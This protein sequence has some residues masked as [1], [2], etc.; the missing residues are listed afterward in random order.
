MGNKL[1]YGNLPRLLLAWV[2]TEA[3]RTQRREL[4]LGRSL[5]EFMRR[6]GIYSTSGGTWGIRTRLRNQMD[7]LFNAHVQLIHEDE[8]GKQFIS[9]TIADQGE[10][11][12]DPK[13][14]NEPVLW[15]SKIELGE[16]P[17]PGD[18]PAPRPAGHEHPESNQA[19]LAGTGPLHMAHLPDL[20]LEEAGEAALAGSLPPV[21]GEPGAGGKQ[22]APWMPSG[23][24]ASG[25]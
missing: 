24:I 4:I 2:C 22:G 20:H 25:S 16:K 12:W 14:P 6:L 10:F 7:R 8:H 19:V 18:H 23:Q 9:S 17:L 1:P 15:D 13:R 21:R 5:S 11:W 3:V